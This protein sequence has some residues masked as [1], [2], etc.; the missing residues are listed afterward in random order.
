MLT[1]SYDGEVKLWSNGGEEVKTICS[2][3]QP[4]FQATFSP[5]GKRVLVTGNLPYFHVYRNEQEIK[6]VGFLE[7]HNN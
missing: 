7:F 1:A 4:V 2:L 3:Q 5:S 6:Q